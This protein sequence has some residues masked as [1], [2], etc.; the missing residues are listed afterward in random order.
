M[1]ESP[2]LIN[3]VESTCICIMS[4]DMHCYHYCYYTHIITITQFLLKE[5]STFVIAS[6][7]FFIFIVSFYSFLV[8]TNEESM[9]Y[10][11]QCWS[12]TGFP[13]DLQNRALFTCIP[14]TRVIVPKAIPLTLH[15][16]ISLPAK[17][18][19]YNIC[20]KFV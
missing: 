18:V 3:L 9:N 19:R 5:I 20:W 13:V 11:Q 4:V 10:N 7:I 15:P 14:V 8:A 6:E 2:F 16:R 12:N 1:F 17:V